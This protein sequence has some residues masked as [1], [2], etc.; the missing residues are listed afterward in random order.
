ME[1]LREQQNAAYRHFLE[2]KETN[3]LDEIAVLSHERKQG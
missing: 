1:K 2:K 3:M